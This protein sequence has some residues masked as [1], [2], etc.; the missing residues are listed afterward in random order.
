MKPNLEYY[1]CYAEMLVEHMQQ[2]YSYESFAATVKLAREDVDKF[3]AKPDFLRA[4]SIGEGLRLKYLESLLLEGRIKL[5]VFTHLT[6][7]ST[8]GSDQLL[9]QF[10][11]SR[12][13]DIKERLKKVL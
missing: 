12:L 6:K 10:D 13:Y 1:S 11:D 5:D 7:E 8:D 4:R 9:Q 3:L 2:G